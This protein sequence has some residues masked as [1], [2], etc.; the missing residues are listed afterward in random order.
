MK[1]F[2]RCPECGSVETERRLACPCGYRE[3]QTNLLDPP[4][5]TRVPFGSFS[6][7]LCQRCGSPPEEGGYPLCLCKDCRNQL[8][9]RPLPIWLLASAVGIGLVTLFAMTQFP[10]ALSAG[11]AFQRGKRAEVAGKHK[12][13]AD[14]YQVVVDRFPN[15]LQARARLGIARFKAGDLPAAFEEFKQLADRKLRGPLADEVNRL[16]AGLKDRLKGDQ[17]P[18]PKERP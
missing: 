15:S 10:K 9:R 7:S 18:D 6:S 11:I 12:R 16:L 8:S 5:S 2:Y 14:E 1:G 3:E 17:Q 4:V 13:A